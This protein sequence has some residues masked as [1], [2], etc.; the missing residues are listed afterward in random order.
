[1]QV[2]RETRTDRDT[3]VIFL[4]DNGMA[5]PFAKTNCYLNSTHT[6]LMVR[7]PGH[8]KPGSV[9][10]DHFVSGIDL[11]PTILEAAGVARPSGMD[12]FSCVPVLAGGRQAGRDMVFTQFHETSGQAKFPMRCVQNARF[13]YIFSPWA[14]GSREFRNESMGGRT[15]KAM[16]AEAASNAEVAA[17]VELFLHRTVEEFYDFE[18]DPNALHNLVE[19]GAYR[20]QVDAFRATLEA[21]MV[22]TED[23]ALEALRNRN[24]PEELKAWMR[25]G[26]RPRRG[27]R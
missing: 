1:M 14:D 26:G 21:W 12:G 2:L 17:R 7:W 25:R 24:S 4:S 16:K 19:V 23:P 18:K 13:G 27:R 5:F 11:M 20:R 22:K 8:V 10:G 9:D 3:L 15:F 6:P